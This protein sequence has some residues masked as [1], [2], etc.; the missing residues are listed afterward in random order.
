MRHLKLNYLKQADKFEFDVVAFFPPSIPL[1]KTFIEPFLLWIPSD[2]FAA[3]V[4]SI[5]A[6]LLMKL[7]CEV[8][9][10]N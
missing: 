9:S 1:F 4:K 5:N 10:E 7:F 2:H 3:Y 6:L 8:F